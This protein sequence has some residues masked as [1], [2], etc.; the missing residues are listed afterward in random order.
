MIWFYLENIKN[1]QVN[2]K[3]FLGIVAIL[4]AKNLKKS[5]K[6][7][8]ISEFSIVESPLDKIKITFGELEELAEQSKYKDKRISDF[9]NL[10]SHR[11]DK[12]VGIVRESRL[13][14]RQISNKKDP[15]SIFKNRRKYKKI[16]TKLQR[17][18]NLLEK[19][20]RLM[21]KMIRFGISYEQATKKK[22]IS[23]EPYSHNNSYTFL[24]LIK[25][26]KINLSLRLLLTNRF[27][28]F[29]IDN[30]LQNGYHLAAKRNFHSLLY[31]LIYFRG[32][33]DAVDVAGK[34]PLAWAVI[35]N[36][37]DSVRILL[38]AGAYPFLKAN[39]DPHQIDDISFEMK[40]L[41][42][43]GKLLFVVTKMKPIKIQKEIWQIVYPYLEE[44]ELDRYESSL[45]FRGE[46]RHYVVETTI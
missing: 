8:R 10:L 31:H 3:I 24:Q 39:L 20:K 18:M 11:K 17:R 43:R 14:L 26:E 13:R 40:Q 46:F 19:F 33:I 6:N 45:K 32:D 23:N 42:N 15:N 22:I 25:R 5:R 37:I 28:I 4:K 41:I 2:F 21:K 1:K 16:G 38:A 12:M 9:H 44:F 34:T 7:G 35:N 27:L 29:Q 30:V 36:N